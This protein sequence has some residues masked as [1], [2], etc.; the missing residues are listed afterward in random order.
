MSTTTINR[1]DIGT[2]D[3]GTNT[4]GT[5]INTTY[6]GLAIYDKIDAILAN[7]LTLG[8][9]TLTVKP[10]GATTRISADGDAAQQQEF[11]WAKAGTLKFQ[12][13]MAASGNDL[14]VYD[15]AGTGGQMVTFQKNGNVGIGTTTPNGKLHLSTGGGLT[16]F[17]FSDT[18]EGTDRKNWG[19]QTG[20]SIG[21]GVIRLR[22]VDDALSSGLNALVCTRTGI[23]YVAVA[24]PGGGLQVGVPTGGDKGAGTINAAGAYH[25][26]GTAGVAT[27]GPSAVTSITVKNGIITAIS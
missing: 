27:F 26:N 21:T 11:A 22:A 9:A 19:W 24:L 6:I 17:Y 13:F 12:L 25:A 23:T 2:N 8:G 7:S 18:S 14:A 10:S 16:D 20:T 4:T 3:D 15:S 1:A 5:V